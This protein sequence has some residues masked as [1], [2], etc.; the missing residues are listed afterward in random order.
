M[1]NFAYC[2]LNVFIALFTGAVY[3]EP[4]EVSQEGVAMIL[5]VFAVGRHRTPAGD[6]SREHPYPYHPA[7]H[8]ASGT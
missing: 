2:S 7:S 8:Q 1:L 4:A 3:L 6:F 5:R